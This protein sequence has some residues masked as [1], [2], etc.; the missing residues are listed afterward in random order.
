MD[1][2]LLGV[3]FPQRF[4]FKMQVLTFC[5]RF[6]APKGLVS[7]TTRGNRQKVQLV[8]ELVI[9]RYLGECLCELV[10]FELSG[11][12]GTLGALGLRTWRLG[13]QEYLNPKSM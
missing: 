2:G 13:V 9:Q 4:R 3:E 12:R 8:H 5:P 10:I 1:V 6:R 11:F 7:M